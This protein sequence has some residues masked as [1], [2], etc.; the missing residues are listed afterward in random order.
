MNSQLNVIYAYIQTAV[1]NGHEAPGPNFQHEVEVPDLRGLAA[2]FIL[3]FT[4]LTF[5]KLGFIVFFYRLGNMI[6]K[7]RVLWLVILV[8]T[9]GCM[10]T[11]IG[12]TPWSCLL[13]DITTIHTACH[14]TSVLDHQETMNQ[15]TIALDVLS[16]VLSEYFM[17]FT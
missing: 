12:I 17:S 10:S 16:D 9:I 7:F 3:C 5:I 8:L 1:A 14:A 6:T 13:S 2:N 11:V 4:G 15:L